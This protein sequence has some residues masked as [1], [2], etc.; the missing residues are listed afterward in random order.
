MAYIIRRRAAFVVV[1]AFVA[2]AIVVPVASSGAQTPAGSLTTGSY[3]NAAGTLKYKLYLPSAYRAGQAMPL[4]VALHGCT[5]SAD[6]FR[7]LS[8]F[9]ALADSKGFVVVYPEQSSARNYLS[10][11]NWFQ[12][13]H[14]TRGAGEPSLIAGITSQVKQRYSVDSHRV[15]V[16]GL[17]AG[18]AMA[19]VM[20]ATYPDVYAAVGVGSGCEY[21][22]GA[23]CAG[24]QS[25]DPVQAGSAAYKA[26]GPRARQVPFV[27]FQGD[28]DT[29]VPPINATQLVRAAQV[30]GDLSDDGQLNGSVPTAPTKVVQGQVPGGRSYTVNYYSDGHGGDLGQLWLVHGMGHAWSGGAASQQYSEPSGPNESAAMY[31]FFM[32]H[33]AP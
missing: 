15:Y 8:G 19:E 23:A 25:A 30:E 31:D 7:T 6:T 18:G 28:K 12:T 10:C 11:W 26:M 13:A 1:C 21:G 20:A 29:T 4:V 27:A 5:Q 2:A 9:D 3:S 33:P 22:A 14:Q 16:T 17:S 32:A 24:W